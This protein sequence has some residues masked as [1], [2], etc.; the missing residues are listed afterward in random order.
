MARAQYVKRTRSVRQSQRL[1][2]LEITEGEADLILAL[3]SRVGGHRTKS[4]RKY[5]RR[6]RNSLERTLGISY[7]D[8]HARMLMTPDTYIHMDTYDHLPT[9][10]ETADETTTLSPLEEWERDVMASA[11]VEPHVYTELIRSQAGPM[12]RM[13]ERYGLTK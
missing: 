4:P 8:T 3:C 6:L 13:L 11:P 9:A 7:R 1:V 5:A 2:Q 12:R 10:D